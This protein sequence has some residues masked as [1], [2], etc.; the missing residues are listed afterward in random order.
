[1]EARYLTDENGKRIGVVLDIKEYERLLE[2]EGRWRTFAA[3][4][5]PWPSESA[6]RATRCPWS[7]RSGRSRRSGKSSGGAVNYQVI[8]ERK[9]R[10]TLARL[11]SSRQ[12][13]DRSGRRHRVGDYRV[14]YD[15]HD[16]RREVLLAEVWHRQRGYT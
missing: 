8:V 7:R 1:M 11:P 3:T 5:K 4:T 15:V 12:P 14:L 2:L 10:K 9:A 13:R 6:A 16:D